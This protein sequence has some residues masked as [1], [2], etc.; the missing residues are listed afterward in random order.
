MYHTAAQG[1]HPA[2]LLADRAAFPS[3]EETLVIQLKPGLHK[4]EIPGPQPDFHLF[5]KNI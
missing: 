1:F 4:G 5:M 2:D 3:A